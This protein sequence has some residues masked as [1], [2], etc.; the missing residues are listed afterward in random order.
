MIFY[1]QN[2]MSDP[3]LYLTKTLNSW[4]TDTSAQ[5][6]HKQINPKHIWTGFY[7]LSNKYLNLFQYTLSITLYKIQFSINPSLYLSNLSPMHKMW[8]KV[9]FQAVYS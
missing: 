3:V 4:Q 2:Y 6:H 8:H 5:C 7:I 9:N 1:A